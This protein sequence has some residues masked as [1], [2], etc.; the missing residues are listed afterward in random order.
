MCGGRCES[1]SKKV[2]RVAN[3]GRRSGG[4]ARASCLPRSLPPMRPHRARLP[5]ASPPL[6]TPTRHANR[7]AWSEDRVR[8]PRRAERGSRTRRAVAATSLARR[9]GC[10]V[11]CPAPKRS[12]S[13]S[14]LLAH[15]TTQP[16]KDSPSC[17]KKKMP[18]PLPESTGAAGGT[19]ALRSR[20]RLGDPGVTT[21]PRRVDSR[22]ATPVAPAAT[23]RGRGGGAGRAS[24]E[25]ARGARRAVRTGGA[26]VGA[27]EVVHMVRVCGE[28]VCAGWGGADTGPSRAHEK[29]KRLCCLCASGSACSKREFPAP[30]SKLTSPAS[31]PSSSSSARGSR[32]QKV[33]HMLLLFFFF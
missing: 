10:F 32:F 11:G 21:P 27:T 26:V 30:L 22:S 8:P 31:S 7:V 17:Q 2:S 25:G 13:S 28:C 29:E 3:A 15:T 23:E 20:V 16:H 6:N 24:A 5:P 18:P 9:G 33:S 1:V 4:R 12:P 14:F 19:H